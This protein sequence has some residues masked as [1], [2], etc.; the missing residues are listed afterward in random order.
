MAQSYPLSKIFKCATFCL[1]QYMQIPKLYHLL[2]L[3]T[4]HSTTFT[5]LQFHPTYLCST[6]YLICHVCLMFDDT[7]LIDNYILSNLYIPS[8]PG[9]ADL[10]DSD[11]N[12]V[13]SS[14]SLLSLPMPSLVPPTRCTPSLPHAP[15]Q[16]DSPAQSKPPRP[17]TPAS[18]A[19]AQKG[20]TAP[21]ARGRRKNIDYELDQERQ[22]A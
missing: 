11:T 10:Q 8:P 9:H 2:S 12:T 13:S 18:T 3:D 1:F 15:P 7:Y 21:T 16:T 14:P 19:Q 17:T 22:E 20:W 6:L 5:M 4:R